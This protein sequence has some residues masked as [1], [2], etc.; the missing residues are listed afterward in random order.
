MAKLSAVEQVRTAVVQE[1][2]ARLLTDAAAAE[3]LKAGLSYG[4]LGALLGISRQ[5]AFARYR[6][7]D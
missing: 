1:T 7:Q 3:A 6:P 4:E 2:A 5:A